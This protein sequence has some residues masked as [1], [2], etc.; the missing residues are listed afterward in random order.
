MMLLV[1]KKLAVLFLG[2]LEYLLYFWLGWLCND[3][4]L[5]FLS[6]LALLH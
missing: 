3:G 2:F 4:R 6:L 5:P 1:S